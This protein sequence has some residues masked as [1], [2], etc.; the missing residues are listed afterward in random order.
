MY[1]SVNA[2]WRIVE[3]LASGDSEQ[4]RYFDTFSGPVHVAVFGR[5]NYYYLVY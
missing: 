5:A 1:H 4:W 3:K 2:A